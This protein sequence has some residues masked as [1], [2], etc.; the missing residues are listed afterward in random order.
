MDSISKKILYEFQHS[1]SSEEACIFK[2]G[3]E[4]DFKQSETKIKVFR[5]DNGIYKV[6]VRTEL[7][8]YDHHV[9]CCGIGAHSQHSISIK[10][11]KQW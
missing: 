3:V 11:T 7:R 8:K 9:T 1:T 6:Y 5:G 2:R 4:Y 10:Y